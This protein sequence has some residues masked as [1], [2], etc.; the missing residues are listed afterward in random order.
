MPSHSK[1]SDAAG[2]RFAVVVARFYE[3]YAEALVKD[4]LACLQEA[5]AASVQVADVPGAFELPLVAKQFAASGKVD[6]VICLG[7]VIRGETTHY[8]FVA[9]E[10]A[11]GIMQSSLETGIP[12]IFSVLTTEN[13][14]QAEARLDKGREGALTAIHMARLVQCV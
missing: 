3:D 8:D 6:A 13:R 12:I 7:V 14:A 9:G 2:L 4:T 5:G 11:R 1:A 10:A